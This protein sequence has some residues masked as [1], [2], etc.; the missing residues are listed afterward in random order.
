MNLRTKKQQGFTIV[1]LLIVIV[2]IAILAAI[3][4][5]AYTNVQRQARDTE[6]AANA[7][8]VI[9]AA[10]AYSAKNEGEW[11]TAAE[12]KSFDIVQ[13][14]DS[15]DIT[16]GTTAPAGTNYN[17]KTI[18]LVPSGT[19]ATGVTVYYGSE[20]DSEW[21]SYTAGDVGTSNAI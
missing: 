18:Y 21:K 20:A 3:S 17:V 10:S 2:V 8:S 1:E 12:I 9:D 11:P 14:S 7:K 6:R 4:I 5:V 19:P 16:D 15:L 13:V